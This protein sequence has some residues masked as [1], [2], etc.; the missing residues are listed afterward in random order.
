MSHFIVNETARPY[1]KS[2]QDNQV[3]LVLFSKW[4]FAKHCLVNDYQYIWI[5]I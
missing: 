4:V 2:V 1:S 5:V 3:L